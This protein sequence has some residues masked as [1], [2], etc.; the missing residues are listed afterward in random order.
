MS[1]ASRIDEAFIVQYLKDTF[2]ADV[3]FAMDAWFFFARPPSGAPSDHMFPFVTVVTSDAHDQASNL[4]RPGVYRL[5]VGVS[6]DTYRARFGAPSDAHAPG[7]HD[8]TA[9]DRILPHP[10]YAAQSWI[11][12]LNPGAET[13]RIL[14]PLIAEAHELAARREAKRAQ[15]G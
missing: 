8:F 3:V 1:H 9:L 5:N 6:R 14:E 15:R 12:V 10:V 7:A 2:D 11:C 4:G 13:F